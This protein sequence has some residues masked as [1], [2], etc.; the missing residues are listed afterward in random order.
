MKKIILAILIVAAALM[1]S[2]CASFTTASNNKVVVPERVKITADGK[3]LEKFASLAGETFTVK[4]DVEV[5]SKDGVIERK[6]DLKSDGFQKI[7]NWFVLGGGLMIVV[8]ILI[9]VFKQKFTVAI[10]CALSGFLIVSG[11]L[12]FKIYAAAIALVVG[13]V[14][15]GVLGW[16]AWTHR[17]TLIAKARDLADNGKLD[18]STDA[19]KP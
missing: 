1:L 17:K 8:G 11:T 13:I 18:G 19:P 15:I 9:A 4:N 14:I 16:E 2:G 12:F 5:K 3:A 10:G 7:A 6:I